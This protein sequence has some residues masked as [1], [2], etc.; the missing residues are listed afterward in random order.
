MLNNLK[1]LVAKKEWWTIIESYPVRDLGVPKQICDA[2]GINETWY[3]GALLKRIQDNPDFKLEIFRVA[4]LEPNVCPQ[5][6]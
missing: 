3:V 5:S 2:L 4:G 6:G 1:A